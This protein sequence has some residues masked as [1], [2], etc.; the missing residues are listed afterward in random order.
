MK[1]LVEQITAGAQ[2]AWEATL[3]K[4]RA[5]QHAVAPAYAYAD[6]RRARAIAARAQRERELR[7]AQ[8][9]R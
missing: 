3:G 9:E 7:N 2:V 4:R 6:R 5:E 1:R 8:R